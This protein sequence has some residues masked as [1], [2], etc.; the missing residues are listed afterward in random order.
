[1]SV[2]TKPDF[3]PPP[4]ADLEIHPTR[5]QVE[6]FQENGF[7]VVERLTTNEEI[8]WIR[9]IFEYIFDPDH[10]GATGAPID[11]SGTLEPGEESRLSQ[12]FFP[13]V[14]FPELLN[15]THRR[16]ALRIAAALLGV[17][18]ERLTTW[19]HMILKPPGGRAALWHQ[20]HAYWFPELD[21]HALG[22]WLPLHDVSVEM[23]AMQFIPGSHR[24]GLLPHRHDD[25]PSANVLIVAD[26]FD[27][28]T[29]VACPL[30]AGGATFHHAETLHFTAPNVTDRPRMAYPMEIQLPPVR[31]SAPK[32][33][34][35]VEETRRAVGTP[36][37]HYVADGKI[38]QI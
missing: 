21:Y 36:V 12:A 15:T 31:R 9:Q 3:G 32:S 10:A 17:D 20:D 30:P 28:S 6:F 18:Q 19:G 35:W 29:A 26:D 38:I 1:M 27:A 24:R 23:G 37:I 34:P 2:S 11:R 5:E 33:M 7:L 8:A 22:V 14:H 16:N 25:V 13:E 4:P